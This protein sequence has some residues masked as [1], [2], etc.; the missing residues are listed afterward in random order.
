MRLTKQRFM[1]AGKTSEGV[2]IR[3][4]LNGVQHSL[5]GFGLRRIHLAEKRD[6]YNIIQEFDLNQD[7]AS[8][9]DIIS[10]AAWMEQ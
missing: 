10:V 7:T 8:K 2:S 3:N 9:N 6:L 1:L 5:S 4:V